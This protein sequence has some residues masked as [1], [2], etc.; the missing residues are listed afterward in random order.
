MKEKILSGQIGLFVS[1]NVNIIRELCSSVF[2]IENG[3]TKM[4][5]V[6]K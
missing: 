5:G 6:E 4:V 1:H 2:W 3:V